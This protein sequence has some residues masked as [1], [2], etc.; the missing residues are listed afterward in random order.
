MDIKILSISGND[1]RIE[2]TLNDGSKVTQTVAGVPVENMD[3]AKDFLT[4]YGSA[5]QDGIDLQ[6][7]QTAA[8]TPASGLVGVKFSIDNA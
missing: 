3:E 1:T 2:F 7:A 6:A 5:L 8:P 4:K